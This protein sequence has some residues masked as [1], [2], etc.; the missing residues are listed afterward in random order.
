[1]RKPSHVVTTWPKVLMT[2]RRQAE[3]P[4]V[5]HRSALP[6]QATFPLATWK[7]IGEALT[8]FVGKL[9]LELS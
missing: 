2:D 3:K 1:M 7:G 8:L 6:S 5:G 4:A 9:K